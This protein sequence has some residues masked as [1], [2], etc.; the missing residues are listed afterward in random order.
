MNLRELLAS[1]D[2][3]SPAD[4]ERL[5]AYLAQEKRPRWPS[6]EAWLAEFDAALDEFWA[7]TSEEERIAILKAISTKSV[8][9]KKE[10]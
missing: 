8:P 4:L 7:D 1:V 10:S 9:S 5:K 3:L 6:G 2:D